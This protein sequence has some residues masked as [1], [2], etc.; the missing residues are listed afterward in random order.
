MYFAS[1]PNTQHPV[2]QAGDLRWELGLTPASQISGS[3][4]RV[5]RQGPPPAA[6]CSASSSIPAFLLLC[7]NC[8]NFGMLG[9]LE[10]QKRE[11]LL[12][13][14]FSVYSPNSC[15]REWCESWGEAQFR[16]SC[17]FIGRISLWAESL[18]RDKYS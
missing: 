8:P 4:K 5:P 9:F 3:P 18:K 16:L 13:S 10:V 6:L 15:P 1:I 11:L 7:S 17:C 12:K 14:P 2:S